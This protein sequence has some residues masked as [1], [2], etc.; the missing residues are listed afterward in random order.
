MNIATIRRTV[1]LW[2]MAGPIMAQQGLKG[3]YYTG[4]NFEHKVFTR[5]DRQLS[6]NWGEDSSPGPGMPHSYYSIRWTGKLFA[7]ATGQYRFYA[8]VDDGIRIWIDNKKVMDSWQ[9]NDSRQYTASIVL[10]AGRYYDLRIDY[11]NDMLEGELTLYWQRPDDKTA[12]R[13]STPDQLISAAFLVQQP[14]PA[15]NPPRPVPKPPVAAVIPPKTTPPKPV[16]A[17][18]PRPVR[19]PAVPAQTSKPNK[20]DKPP[21]ST[22]SVDKVPTD[23]EPDTVFNLRPRRIRFTQSEYVILPES[24]AELDQLIVVMQRHP[25]W[26]ITVAGHTDNVG[27]AR[28]NQYLSEYRAKVVATYLTRRGIAD[29]RITL[30]GYGGTR[31]LTGNNTEDERSQ[32][33]R[34][35]VTIR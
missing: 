18:K 4:T 32:N 35:D 5:I 1:L 20:T 21:V 9:L 30:I 22:P 19:P 8:K 13:N 29:D 33:R 27:D 23:I 12:N 25:L 26:R 11:F 24:A 17:A 10:E 2:L 14:P 34:V 28:V 15:A 16:T 7:P 3:E 31:P 6:F